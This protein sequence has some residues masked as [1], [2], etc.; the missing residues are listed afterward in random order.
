MSTHVLS[1]ALD[2]G[3]LGRFKSAT[4]AVES[5]SA[6]RRDRAF[7]LGAQLQKMRIH[8]SNGEEAKW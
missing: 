3:V 1:L 8:G 5:Y 7:E 2:P 6:K 4:V